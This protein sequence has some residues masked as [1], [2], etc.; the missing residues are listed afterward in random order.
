MQYNMS[1]PA[2]TNIKNCGYSKESAICESLVPRNFNPIR[3]RGKFCGRI[4]LQFPKFG[5]D[6]N[7]CEKILPFYTMQ[8]SHTPVQ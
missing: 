7:F 6:I 2:S 5:P 4:I 1:Y 8:I 3:Y